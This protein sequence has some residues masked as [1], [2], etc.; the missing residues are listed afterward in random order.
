MSEPKPLQPGDPCPQCGGTFVVDTRE[1]DETL[2]ARYAPGGNAAQR[3]AYI[4][5]TKFKIADQG[6]LHRCD[7]CGYQTRF[8]P[9]AAPESKPKGRA[10]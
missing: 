8:K 4:A 2:S 9:A 1:S 6:V 5:R 3:E 7:V 10:A